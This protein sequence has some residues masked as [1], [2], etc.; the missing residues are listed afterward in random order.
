MCLRYLSKIIIQALIA[1]RIF[2]FQ[3]SFR[4]YLGEAVKRSSVDR[5]S[6]ETLDNRAF[7]I[8]NLNLA[9][10]CLLQ[11]RRAR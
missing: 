7:L 9:V 4:S 1:I 8:W 11:F 6:V 10:W 5:S 2:P 3:T